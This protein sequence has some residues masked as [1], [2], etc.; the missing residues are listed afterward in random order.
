MSIISIPHKAVGHIL[1]AISLTATSIQV[2]PAEFEAFV[3]VGLDADYAYAV[4]RGPINREIVK[5]DLAASVTPD[6]TI[7]RGQG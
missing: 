2:S 1:V 3:R 6:L 4:F 5:I 7:A